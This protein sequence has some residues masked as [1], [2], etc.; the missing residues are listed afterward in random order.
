MS[1]DKAIEAS[2]AAAIGDDHALLTELRAAFLDSATRHLEALSAA[3]VQEN[4]SDAAL[5]LK[6]LAASFGAAALMTRAGQA[7]KAPCGDRQILA[8]IEAEL[9]AFG[10]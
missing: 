6:G 2:L 3:E 7:A 9:S 8:A 4:W 10:R 1:F 5:R